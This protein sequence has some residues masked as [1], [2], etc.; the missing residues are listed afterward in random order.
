MGCLVKPFSEW[1]KNI[2]EMG[3]I[4][5]NKEDKENVLGI[6][7]VKYSQNFPP[8]DY[9]DAFIAEVILWRLYKDTS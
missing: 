6:S 3:E 9:I 7:V 4:K 5:A 1:A 8:S 2:P